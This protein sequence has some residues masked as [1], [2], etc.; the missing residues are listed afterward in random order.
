MEIK[1]DFYLLGVKHGKISTN[2]SS[3]EAEDICRLIV[4]EFHR[5]GND[6]NADT[7]LTVANLIRVVTPK[8]E[9]ESDKIR[10]LDEES[11]VKKTKY[12]RLG[13]RLQMEIAA[14]LDAGM[15]FANT[16][17]IISSEYEDHEDDLPEFF[18]LK[19]RGN[20]GKRYSFIYINRKRRPVVN[21]GHHICDRLSNSIAAMCKKRKR[22]NK[23]DKNTPKRGRNAYF[24]YLSDNRK[25]ICDE[26]PELRLAKDISRR[27][28]SEWKELDPS[29]KISYVNRAKEE[30][31]SYIAA[32]AAIAE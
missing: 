6:F 28:G 24:I 30:Q 4:D 11:H 15:S 32:K 12:D 9:S 31:A 1:N 8:S 20:Q 14:C 2:D 21:Q 10:N 29:A 7:F 18:R 25:R 27:L 23:K 17:K 5:S 16:E 19:S 22:K 13:H 3:R 26:N